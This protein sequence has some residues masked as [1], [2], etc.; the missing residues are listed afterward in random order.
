MK[1]IFFRK[2][3][4]KIIALIIAIIL[5]G[6]ISTVLHLIFSKQPAEIL[7]IDLKMIIESIKSSK[8]HFEMFIL[9]I[10]AF[11]MFVLTTVFKIFSLK[12]YKSKTYK[13]THNIEIPMPIGDRQTQQGSSW[14]LKKSETSKVFGI[15]RLDPT[16]KEIQELLRLAQ[17]DKKYISENKINNDNTKV[18]PIFNKGGLV[19]GKRNKYLLK[20]HIKKVNKYIKFPIIYLKKVEDIYFIDDD[21]HSLTVGATRSG[22][23]RNLVIQTIL[24]TGLA[25]ENMIISDP[26]GE[27][28]QYTAKTLERLGYKVLTLDFKT[29][30]KSSR[31]NFLQ[32]VIEAIEKKDIP[33]GVN[34]SSDIVESLVGEVGNRE[35]IWINGEKSVEKTG[36]MAVVME[37]KSNK[38]Y[39]NLPN[40]YHFISKMCAEQTDKTMLMDTFLSTLTDDHPAVASFAAARIAPSKTRASFFTSALATLSIF[41]DSY[42]SSMISE[43]EIDINKFNEEKS[44]LFMILPDEKT[45]FYSL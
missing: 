2:T 4:S 26:K 1:K 22:K 31:Y 45:T 43:S 28:F 33:K 12:D 7:N 32:P 19:V 21:L 11:M 18:E 36:I 35:A 17:L 8:E 42:V 5:S 24:N 16:K 20:V 41:I 40:V 44:V 15:N 39:Q 27:L 6:I 14:W 37:N 38:E 3:I 9:T 23:T 25:G 13:V 34:Y 29:P 30:L 10:I